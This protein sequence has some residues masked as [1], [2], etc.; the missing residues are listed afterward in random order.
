M[1]VSGEHADIFKSVAKIYTDAKKALGISGPIPVILAE[2]ETKVR[3][4][5]SWEARWDTL[6]RFC[7]PIDNHKCIT[8]YKPVVGESE[9]GYSKMVDSFRLD[10]VGGFARVIMVNPMH[11]KLPR[12][13]LVA[14]CTCG[15]F[16]AS[17]VR[18]QWNKIDDLWSKHCYAAVGPILGHGSDG[19]SR[20]RQLMLSDYRGLDGMRLG[21]DWEGWI[22]TSSMNDAGEAT[23]LYDQDY[24]HN[25]KKLL[26]PLDSN[27]CTLRLGADMAMHQHICQVFNRF[28]VDEHGLLQED[29]DKKD[30][31]NWASAQRLCSQ[32]VRDCLRSL[33]VSTDLHRE[34]TLGTEMYLEVC[35]D[36]NDIFISSCYDLRERIVKAGKVFFFSSDYGNYG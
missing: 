27:V 14:C 18:A 9:V 15:C 30:R 6:L 10:K 28:T 1:F 23:G 16:D 31:Q 19:D 21:V 33:R 5:V 36:Y 34:R 29:Y 3:G 25:G 7:G 2:D 12:I 11:E 22:F 35:T 32:K 8:D 13:V 17:W 24:I 26:N 20:R 4:R